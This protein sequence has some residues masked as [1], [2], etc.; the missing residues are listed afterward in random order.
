MLFPDSALAREFWPQKLNVE[1]V[2]F[3]KE[4]TEQRDSQAFERRGN[5]QR[6]K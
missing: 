3:G 2:L 1:E 4:C 6:S 5:Y